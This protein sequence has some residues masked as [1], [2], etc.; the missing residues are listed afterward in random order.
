L[1]AL[2]FYV[3]RDWSRTVAVL[4]VACPCA[5][6]LATPTAMVAAI[7]GL[8][9]ARHSGARR[10]GAATCA[11]VDTVVFDK[12]GHRYRGRFEIVK[13]VAL[14]SSEEDVL[15]LARQPKAARIMCWLA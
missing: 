2:T 1:R 10:H 8:V 4:L 6:I 15:Q 9:S 11:K 12:T 7:G 14:N 3:T 5:L 13:I